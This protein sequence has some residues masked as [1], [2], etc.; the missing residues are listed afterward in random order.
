M[1]APRSEA[2]DDAL[3]DSLALVRASLDGDEEAIAVVAE[4]VAWPALTMATM[5]DWITEMLRMRGLGRDT[6]DEWQ[7]AEG[8]R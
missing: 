3:R 1:M 4:N 7:T 2:R 5:A 6:L 8:L